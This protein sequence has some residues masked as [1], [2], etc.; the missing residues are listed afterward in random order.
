MKTNTYD[1]V[2][3]R[4][5]PQDRR[6][7][8]L[9]L[10]AV[11]MVVIVAVTAFAIDTGYI[12]CARTQLRSAADSAVLAG[13]G[14]LTE[15]Q[16]L[17]LCRGQAVYYS[18]L[19][20]PQSTTTISF[21]T[22]NPTSKTFT[23]GTSQPNA[24]RALVSRTAANNDSIP[25][26]FAKIFGLDHQDATAEAI[27]SGATAYYS[28][29]TPP[30]SVY[31]TSTKDLSNVV[32]QFAPDDPPQNPPRPET[33]K[34]ESLTGYTGTFSGTGVNAGREIIGVW[35][36]SGENSSGDGP[37]YGEYVAKPSDYTGLDPLTIHGCNQASKKIPHVTATFQAIGPTFSESG[38]SSPV[39][40]VQ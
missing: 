6:G 11:M 15:G 4:P 30:T 35:I 16:S 21:G 23:S 28:G 25:L 27:A 29:T 14:A 2:N 3:R 1:R 34:F 36:K 39:R 18:N 5:T 33:Q 24:V 10:V 40:L 37:G 7:S 31:V 38:S 20:A 26:F 19:N 8:M 9:T 13:A 22:W 17:D 32:L 12:V